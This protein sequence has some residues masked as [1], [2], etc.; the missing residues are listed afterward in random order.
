M[1]HSWVPRGF[2]VGQ[3]W[4]HAGHSTV[5]IAVTDLTAVGRIFL[6]NQTSFLLPMA[7]GPPPKPPL[8]AREQRLGWEPGRPQA[9]TC[10]SLSP[11]SPTPRDPCAEHGH[12]S[13][14]P[15]HHH[16][17]PPLPQVFILYFKPSTFRCIALRW[18]RVLGFAIVYG[19]ITLKLYR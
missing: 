19:T 16:H 2:A 10:H 7:V 8:C 3:D 9:A 18:V 13:A 6:G 17:P 11:F 5:G 12:G 15:H 1:G 4:R 14:A